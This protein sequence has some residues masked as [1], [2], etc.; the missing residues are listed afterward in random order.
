M[1]YWVRFPRG[2]FY[3]VYEEGASALR[4]LGNDAQVDCALRSYV[5]RHAYAIAQPG[6]LLDELNRLIPGAERRLRAWGIHR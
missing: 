5:A 6:D 2:Y 3:G 4:S 1:T